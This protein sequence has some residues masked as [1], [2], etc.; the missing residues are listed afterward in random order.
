MS[1]RPRIGLACPRPGER[2]AFQE[3]L[4]TAKFVPVPMIDAGSIVREL[5]GASF[6]VLIIDAD[7][8]AAADTSV[9]LRR[10]GQNRPMIVIGD[11]G[12]PIVAD[13]VR[14]GVTYLTRPVERDALMLAVALALGEGRPVRRSP[15]RAVMGLDATVDGVAARLLDVSYE[16]IRLELPER[17]R[18]CVPP[19]FTVRVP[20]FD[21][22]VEGRRV[23]VNALDRVPG[24]VWCGVRL[25]K[26]TERATTAWQRLVESAPAP[27]E[28]VSELR[29]YL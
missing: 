23:W 15:R 7:L 8:S 26:H 9:V 28:T 16:G 22:I 29:S 5:A 11:V 6:E 27:T 20:M 13:A 17:H 19:I 18:S 12:M 4:D 24:A 21:V 3:W 25:G 2:A 1:N 10:L 14:S